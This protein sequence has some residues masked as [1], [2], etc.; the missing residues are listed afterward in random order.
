[1]YFGKDHTPRCD[2]VCTNCG[3]TD[4]IDHPG[5]AKTI[6]L[7]WEGP[8]KKCAFCGAEF[9][10]TSPAQRY[11]APEDNPECDYQRT[12]SKMTPLQYIRF[13]G[14]NSK[15]DFIRDMGQDAWDAIRK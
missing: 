4:C 11:C 1:M 7:D 14:Y 6:R 8:P 3:N 2:E 10:P 13:H 5:H 9:I 12:V 15:E